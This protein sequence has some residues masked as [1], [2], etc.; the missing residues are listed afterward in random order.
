MYNVL[1]ADDETWVIFGLKRMIEKSGLP[2]RVIGETNDGVTTL[3]EVEKKKPDVLFSDI[4]MPGYTG[5]ELLEHIQEKK[6]DVK[7]VFV[8]GYAEFTYAQKALSLG[9]VD[10]LL[11]PI[12]P[13][14]MTTVLKKL[15]VKLAGKVQEE[16]IEQKEEKV[17]VI[18]QII[19]EI[20]EH[21]TEN[22]T[23]T[24][25][26]KKYGI[27]V[28]YL[29]SLIKENVGLSYSDYVT[30]RRIQ[31]AKE[32]LED[33]RL[34][35]EQIAE[36]TGFRDHFYFIKVFKKHTGITPGKYRKHM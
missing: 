3:E 16:V 5:L 30:A 6:L 32:L 14:M 2:F 31:K 1:I 27:S 21:Y 26:A 10:Y 15:E 34:S 19:T 7:V 23:L 35:M 28:G 36:Q 18:E 9:A 24:E 8:S 17:P 25:L 12:K 33:E 20:Q 13:D 11:K 22:I 4:R 29:S